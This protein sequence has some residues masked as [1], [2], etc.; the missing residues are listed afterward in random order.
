MKQKRH[1]GKTYVSQSF[2]WGLYARNGHRLLCGDGIIRAAELAES[3]DTFFSVPARVRVRG[4]WVSGYMT[5]EENENGESVYAF[6][7]NDCHYDAI[8]QWPK[9]FTEFY[10]AIITRVSGKEK[11]GAA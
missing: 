4:K 3:A 9:R 2:P 11:A 7:S 10:N 5:T 1:L 6:R 8:P